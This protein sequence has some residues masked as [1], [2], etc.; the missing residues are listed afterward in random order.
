MI[1]DNIL[2]ILTLVAALG[3][4][5]VAGIFFAFSAFVM[6]ALAKLPPAQGIAAMQSINVA[7]LNRL[8]FAVFFGSAAVCVL[9]AGYSLFIRERPPAIYLLGGSLFYLVGTILVTIMFNVPRNNALASLDPASA[10]G[11]RIW[12]NYVTSWTI[13]NHVRTIAP[14][15]AAGLLTIALCSG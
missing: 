7:V 1:M 12:A 15:A 3:C 13:W 10:D 8:F 6:R 4:G 14:L 2:F 11:P 5:L 9:L